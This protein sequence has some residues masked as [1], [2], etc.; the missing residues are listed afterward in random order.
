MARGG[1]KAAQAT[2]AAPL[3]KD[4]SRYKVRMPRRRTSH[5]PGSSRECFPRVPASV[6]FGAGLISL[7]RSM[8]ACAD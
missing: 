3:I 8:L 2:T 4:P 1:K 6:L 7:L 5:E